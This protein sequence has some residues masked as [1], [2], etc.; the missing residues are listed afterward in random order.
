[1]GS[2]FGAAWATYGFETAVCYTREFRNPATDTYRAIVA[3]GALCIVTFTLVPLAF[4]GSLGLETLLDPS[5]ADGTGVAFALARIVRGGVVVTNVLVVMMILALL[6]IVNSSMMGS[7][8]TLYQAS[9]DGWL[10]KYLSRIN[11]HGAPTAA[12]WTDLGFI[13]FS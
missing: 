7:S 8:R 12:M 1:M 6:L 10:P 4:L 11:K 9:V 5:I 3:S 2:M 13:W